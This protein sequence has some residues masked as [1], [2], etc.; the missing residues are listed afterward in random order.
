MW[1]SIT[2]VILK[3]PIQFLNRNF[4]HLYKHVN[5]KQVK[6]THFMNKLLLNLDIV[7]QDYRFCHYAS[8]SF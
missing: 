7:T 6:I 5:L 3:V 2:F 4:G 1:V 8:F